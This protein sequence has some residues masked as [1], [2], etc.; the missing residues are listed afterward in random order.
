ME[1]R[2]RGEDRFYIVDG[3]EVPSVTTVLSI[4]RRPFLERWRG[5]LG[6]EE[7]DRIRDEAA[8]LGQRLHHLCLQYHQ[9]Q[10]GF[11][12]WDKPNVIPE[13]LGPMFMAYLHWFNAVVEK[14]VVCEIAIASKSFQYAGT[15]D[16]LA[17][18]K[19][20]SEPSVVDL[21]TSNNFWP[22]MP[23]QLAAYRHALQENGMKAQRR[24]VV[25]VDK[26]DQGRV[27]VKEYT[28][29]TRDFNAFVAA[30]SLWGY[31]NG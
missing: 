29:H 27:E 1:V 10:C 3:K 25:R 8:D 9:V 26:V 11:A 14:V 21:K 16:L 22:D 20:D 23:L 12:V 6:N 13:E 15:L 18:I 24:L 19:G 31:F 17:V 2:Q 30:R 28:Q 7:A 4:I 5:R